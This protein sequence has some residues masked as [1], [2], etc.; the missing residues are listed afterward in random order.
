MDQ[1]TP[2]RLGMSRIRPRMTP[3]PQKKC[4]DE[5]INAIKKRSPSNESIES[6]R[7]LDAPL[8]KQKVHHRDS[9]SPM[10]EQINNSVENDYEEKTEANAKTIDEL[11]ADIRQLKDQLAK[12]EKYKNEKEELEKLIEAWK[13]GGVEAVQQLQAEIQPRQEIESILKHFNLSAEIFGFATD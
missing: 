4:T 3:T 5:S 6:T 10:K 11:N 1:R 8:K 2:R 7:L 9:D 13:A 12:Y